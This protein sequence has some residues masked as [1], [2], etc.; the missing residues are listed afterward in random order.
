MLFIPTFCTVKGRRS[1]S[2]F[3]QLVTVVVNTPRIA[4]AFVHD[5]A[6][7]TVAMKHSHFQKHSHFCNHKFKQHCHYANL[8]SFHSI[9]SMKLQ[10]SLAKHKHKP[11]NITSSQNIKHYNTNNKND[12][13]Q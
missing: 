10:H 6:K 12:N 13:T 9:D 2:V 11:T 3:A 8:A 1:K 4:L 5:Y 7:A